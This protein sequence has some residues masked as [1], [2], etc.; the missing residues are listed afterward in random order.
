MENRVVTV[1]EGAVAIKADET[2]D[3]VIILGL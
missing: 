1:C 2:E 3:R